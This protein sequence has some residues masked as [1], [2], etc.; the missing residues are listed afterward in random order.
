MNEEQKLFNRT[1]DDP[2]FAVPE[3]QVINEASDTL[4][5]LT[6]FA[7]VAGI[8]IAGLLAGKT[9]DNDIKSKQQGLVD[10]VADVSAKCTQGALVT[11]QNPYEA[12][13][14]ASDG[15]IITCTATSDPAD[16]SAAPNLTLEGF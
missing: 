8:C 10:E 4:E 1:Q 6:A 11:K 5:T 12:D 3:N 14:K 13:F 7:R 9:I 15:K 16:P 2:M